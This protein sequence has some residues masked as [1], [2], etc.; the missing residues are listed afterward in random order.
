MDHQVISNPAIGSGETGSLA[1]F[2]FSAKSTVSEIRGIRQIIKKL[3]TDASNRDNQT[4]QTEVHTGMLSIELWANVE[5]SRGE[6]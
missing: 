6:E 1:G 3:L 2:R 5:G 4:R